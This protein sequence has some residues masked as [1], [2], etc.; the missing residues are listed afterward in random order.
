[1]GKQKKMFM[2]NIHGFLVD[3]W[4]LYIGCQF[5]YTFMFSLLYI[6][7]IIMQCNCFG[8][9]IY[10]FK[11]YLYESPLNFLGGCAISRHNDWRS[12]DPRFMHNYPNLFKL[13]S[14]N[15]K[16]Y[17][18][19]RAIFCWTKA[20]HLL[21]HANICL[22]KSREI[23]WCFSWTDWHLHSYWIDNFIVLQHFTYEKVNWRKSN[24]NS[25]A[26]VLQLGCLWN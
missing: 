25:F 6:F 5:G 19:I 4:K 7:S 13:C 23:F 22:P 2:K 12:N 8:N 21:F 14:K 17:V 15:H 10:L 11:Y 26:I 9:V 3:F 18:N 24:K 1:M 20:R 16:H